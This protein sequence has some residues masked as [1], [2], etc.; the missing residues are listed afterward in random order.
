VTTARDEQITTGTDRVAEVARRL[1]TVRGVGETSA[2]VFSAELFGTRTFSNGRQLGAL[3]GLVPVPYRSDQGVRDQG[4]SKAGRAELRRMWLQ[5][6]WG[7]LRW[8]PHRALTHW[9]QGPFCRRRG[10][11]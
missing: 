1:G 7:W 11:E 6:A 3:L 4:I 2:A 10:T 5:I 9:F 8:Q